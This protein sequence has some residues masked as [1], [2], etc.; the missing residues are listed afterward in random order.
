MLN[1]AHK[2]IAGF[3][4][5]ELLIV[6]VL[7]AIFAL[8]IIPQFKGMADDTRANSCSKTLDH[9]IKVIDLYK[10]QN[11]EYP[12]T[13]ESKLFVGNLMPVNPYDPT[14]DPVFRISATGDPTKLHPKTKTVGGAS[15]E[16][17]FWY[18]TANGI[19]RA[20][21]EAQASN[22]ETI[23]LYNRVNRANVTKLN[24]TKIN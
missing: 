3:T 1:K 24:Q 9:I 14:A 11:G 15:H 10:L 7:L 18:N 22:S 6:L 23:A 13:I 4:L 5:I 2:K 8:F 16:G 20:R 17:A 12:A 19:V 21:V